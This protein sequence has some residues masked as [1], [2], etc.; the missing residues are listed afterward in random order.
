MPSKTYLPD[1]VATE[2]SETLPRRSRS[3]SFAQRLRDN[4]LMSTASPTRSVSALGG[5]HED[6]IHAE[7]GNGR[8]MRIEDLESMH[9]DR[10]SGT[11]GDN[12][13]RVEHTVTVEQVSPSTK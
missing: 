6:L 12:D 11:L 10:K 8:F 2:I 7:E 13:I 5:D 3:K 1:P 4:V 9:S